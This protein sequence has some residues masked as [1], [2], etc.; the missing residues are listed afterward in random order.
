MYEPFVAKELEGDWYIVMK[1]LDTPQRTPKFDDV[2]DSVLAAWQRREAAKLAETRA[3]ELAEEA[4]KSDK[5]FDQ[6]IADKGYRVIPRTEFFSWRTYPADS[7]GSGYQP[8]ISEVADLNNLGTD[9]MTT[10][11]ALKGNETEAILN[12]DKSTAYV[13]RL[14][15]QQYAD[16][17]LKKLFLEDFNSWGG[18]TEMYRGYG[19]EFGAAALQEMETR[20]GFQLNEEWVKKRNQR[21]QEAR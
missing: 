18:A 9:F 4:E 3:K 10:A 17:E 12:F 16:D 15:R 13:V 2:R 5:P 11:F 1:T 20:A 14:D 7:M 19:G 8:P 6:F 21:A